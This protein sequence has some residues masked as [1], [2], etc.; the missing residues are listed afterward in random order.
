M[1]VPHY[2][3]NLK[4]DST[5]LFLHC[6]IHSNPKQNIYPIPKSSR[7]DDYSKKKNFESELWGHSPSETLALAKLEKQIDSR[8]YR[9]YTASHWFIMYTPIH[10]NKYLVKPVPSWTPQCEQYA[11]ER[12]LEPSSRSCARVKCTVTWTCSVRKTSNCSLASSFLGQGSFRSLPRLSPVFV[13]DSLVGGL[14][15]WQGIFRVFLVSSCSF[16]NE[17]FAEFIPRRVTGNLFTCGAT[18]AL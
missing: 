5:T 13:F 14:G 3:E 9:Y 18:Y 7:C 2:D 4:C 6:I 11:N 8:T 12:L 15:L 16:K 1:H 10:L 17:Q